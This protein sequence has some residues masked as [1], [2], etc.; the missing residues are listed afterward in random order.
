MNT[1][2]STAPRQTSDVPVT[3]ALREKVAALYAKPLPDLLFQAQN[4]HRRHHKPAEIQK[5][6]LLSIK[7]GGCKENCAYCAQSAH[8]KTGVKATR[9][10]SVKQTL[11]AA[12][13][14]QVNGNTRFCMGASGTRVQDGAGF[15]AILEMVAAVKTLGLESCCTLGMLTPAQ[16][17]RLKTAGLDYYNHNIDTSREY[18]KQII[19]TRHFTERIATLHTVRAAGIAICTGGILGMGET[20]E[21]RIAF[22]CEL[23]QFTPPPESITI[24]K[25]VP[26]PGTPLANAA[27]LPWHEFIRTIATLRISAPRS[28]IRLSAGRE[29]MSSELQLLAFMAG[30]N[31]IFSGEK[32]LTTRNSG[33]HA[34]NKLFKELGLSTKQPARSVQTPRQSAPVYENHIT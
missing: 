1:S 25:L 22:I 12:K 11:A 29:T 21:D 10:M 8:F 7:T 27:P 9:L 23:L 2:N 4:I 5:S 32:L 34:D 16:A 6:V 13:S 28:A 17:K 19:T 18:Y 31:S 33:T 30:A 15:D 26:I 14:A 3:E 20:R 24:N